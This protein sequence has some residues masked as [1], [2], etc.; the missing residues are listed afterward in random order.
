[1]TCRYCSQK[2]RWWQHYAMDGGVPYA[3]SLCH[4]VYQ[5]GYYRG[6]AH[7]SLELL[8]EKQ[9]RDVIAASERWAA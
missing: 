4:R 5:H 1:M 3:H 8:T 2:I 6:I 9:L 7:R